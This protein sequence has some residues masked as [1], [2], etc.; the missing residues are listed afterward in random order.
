MA[1]ATSQVP[2]IVAALAPP[3]VKGEELVHQ[4]AEALEDEILAHREVRQAQAMILA[5]LNRF[6]ALDETL[7][8]ELNLDDLVQVDFY[9]AVVRA[10]LSAV[11]A[12]QASAS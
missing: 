10:T 9:C 11:L 2:W 5:G 12:R 1:T 6:A 7:A 4:L 3:P 8:D